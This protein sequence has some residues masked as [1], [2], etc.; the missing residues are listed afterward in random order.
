MSYR[1]A[2]QK[3][4]DLVEYGGVAILK[5]ELS[6]LGEDDL[7]KACDILSPLV[8]I[9]PDLRGNY[10][11][12]SAG[13]KVGVISALGLRIQV[14]PRISAS[15]FCALV[16]YV[17]SGRTPPTHFR[18][19]S[20]LTWDTGFEDALS[21]L[22][23]DEVGE[24]LRIGLSRQY[25]ER[26]DPLEVLRGRVLWEK[27]FP[28]RGAKAK[29]LVCRYH[30]LTYDN[31]DNRLVFSGLRSARALAVD[32]SV[33][34]SV[35]QHCKTFTTIASETHPGPADF[36]KASLGY[37]RLNEHYRTAHGISRML[38]FGLRPKDFFE[39]GGHVISGVVLDMASLFEG[40]V[41]RFMGDVLGPSGFKL[42]LQAPDRG[43]LLDAKGQ[44]Y[45]S[46]RPDLEAWMSDQVVGVIDAKYKPYWKA[47]DESLRPFRKISNE[48]LYQLFFY[49]Q[50][51]QRR[52][53]LLFPPVAVIAAPLPD[54]DEMN[55]GQ[56]I[57]ERY[58]RVVW[59]AGLERAGDVRLVLIPMT[60]FLRLMGQRL[61]P[62][63]AVS[64]LGFDDFASLFRDSS[65]SQEQRKALP[66][67]AR[68]V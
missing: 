19:L 33:H 4:V 26:R 32:R 40:F 1:E 58:K 21:R 30:Q 28:W 51:L 14:R 43:A 44:R 5:D 61:K 8:S 55:G 35:L 64:L 24:I 18:S 3:T 65:W 47:A 6:F 53:D 22:L 11:H 50:R 25:E 46:V 23:C 36:E 49:Q 57:S 10:L 12:V 17:L 34:A 9:S 60:R 63:E 41:Q 48:D 56:T 42:I 15:E 13:S 62:A 37:N 68:A 27:N 16:R 54:E 20:E 38:V 39:A 45:A 2:V 67:Q 59:Q 7:E 52:H 66:V 29:E 31:L